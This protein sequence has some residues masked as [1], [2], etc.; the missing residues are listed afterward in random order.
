MQ[1]STHSEGWVTD[2]RAID[3]IVALRELR[4]GDEIIWKECPGGCGPVEDHCHGKGWEGS[5]FTLYDLQAS[6]YKASW[7]ANDVGLVLGSVSPVQHS[8][9]RRNIGAWRRPVK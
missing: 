7:T 8:F 2:Q 9:A 1:N 3:V 5:V 6:P 4:D